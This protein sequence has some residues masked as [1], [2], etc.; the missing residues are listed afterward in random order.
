MKLRDALGELQKLVKAQQKQQAA[1]AKDEIADRIAELLADAPKIGDTTMFV[2]ELPDLP[3]DQLKT[4]ADIVKQ[5]C[6]SAVVLFAVN[7]GEKV[8]LLAAMSN[9]LV[10]QGIK[11][12]DLIKHVAPLVDGRGGGPPTMA[13]AGGKSPEKIPAALDA[14]RAWIKEKLG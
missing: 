10:K 7:A 8:M 4:G 14:G 6:K 9:D 1:A 12:G 13:Q 2:A 11:A 3:I 5:K